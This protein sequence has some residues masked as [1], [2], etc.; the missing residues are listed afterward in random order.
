[1]PNSSFKLLE[2]DDSALYSG[3]LTIGGLTCTLL[4]SHSLIGSHYWVSLVERGNQRP[5]RLP[6]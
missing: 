2:M 5:E 1:M 4:D 3:G 6:D